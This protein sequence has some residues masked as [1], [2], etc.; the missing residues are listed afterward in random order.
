VT[1]GHVHRGPGSKAWRGLYVGGDYCGRLF[2][3]DG[4]GRVRLAF[5]SGHTLSSFGEDAAGRIFAV[6]LGGTIYQVRFKGPRP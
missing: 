4:A 1:G 2:V 3:L 6:D 5:D